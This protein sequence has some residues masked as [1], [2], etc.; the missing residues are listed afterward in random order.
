MKGL[1]MVNTHRESPLD[2]VK[3]DQVRFS[4]KGQF[5]LSVLR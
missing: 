4:D 1:C 5:E 2:S 3:V